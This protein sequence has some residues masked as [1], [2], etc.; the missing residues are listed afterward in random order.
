MEAAECQPVCPQEIEGFWAFLTSISF[1]L[2]KY[3]GPL[4]ALE[5]DVRELLRM[6]APTSQTVFF[7]DLGAVWKCL[8]VNLVGMDVPFITV[9]IRRRT[10][11]SASGFAIFSSS[12]EDTPT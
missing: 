5:S 12:L 4:A 2:R 8:K 1:R 3:I 7:F 9:P 6:D 11:A 10:T